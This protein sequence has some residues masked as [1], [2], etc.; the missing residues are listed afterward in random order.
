MRKANLILYTFS[1]ADPLVKSRLLQCYCLSLYGC[2]LWN[3][4]CPSL[5][6]IEVSFKLITFLGKSGGCC[7]IATQESY[8]LLLIFPVSSMLFFLGLLRYVQ[9][10]FPVLRRLFVLFSWMLACSFTLRPDITF[11]TVTSM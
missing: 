3:I 5:R 9:A 1:A 7:K 6:T 10:L 8:I 4:S 2:S 11:C